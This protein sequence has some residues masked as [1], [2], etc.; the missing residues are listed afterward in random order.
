MKV[1][2]VKNLR[3]GIFEKIQMDILKLET[4]NK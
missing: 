4:G 3:E 1:T 2:E